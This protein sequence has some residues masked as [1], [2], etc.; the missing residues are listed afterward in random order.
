MSVSTCYTWVGSLRGQ[1]R[2]SDPPAAEV[3][4]SHELLDGDDL[5]RRS[6][7]SVVRIVNYRVISTVSWD[8]P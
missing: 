3:A 7:E 6:L 4:S 8:A 2:A 1:R 5:K